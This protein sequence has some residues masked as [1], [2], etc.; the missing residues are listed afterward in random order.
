MIRRPHDRDIPLM[1][2][3]FEKGGN[4][5][6]RSHMLSILV[7]LIRAFGQIKRGRKI[8]HLRQAE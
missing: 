3:A 4:T 5:C 1:P 7:D 2:S 6:T 8:A